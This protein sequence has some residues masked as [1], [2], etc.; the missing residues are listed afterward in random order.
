MPDFKRLPPKLIQ[1]IPPKAVNLVSVLRTDPCNIEVDPTLWRYKEVRVYTNY[2][3]RMLPARIRG[4][5]AIIATPEEHVRLGP[6]I[7]AAPPC[8]R[9]LIYCKDKIEAM[10]CAEILYPYEDLF[11]ELDDKV[12][13]R[14]C[15]KWMVSWGKACCKML[16]CVDPLPYQEQVS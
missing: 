4:P 8:G 9:T 14:T 16:Y 7:L 1:P 15:P 11:E 12:I 10:K 5:F 2:P 3:G 6:Y 13:R